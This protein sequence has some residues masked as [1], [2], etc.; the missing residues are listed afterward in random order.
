MDTITYKDSYPD[1][2][3]LR[4]VVR[5]KCFREA[6]IRDNMVKIC[7]GLV[8]GCPVLV[9]GYKVNGLREFVSNI[10]NSIKTL[11]LW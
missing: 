3:E 1:V 8:I 4:V 7:V 2:M 6:P 11:A 10:E 9:A 5:N